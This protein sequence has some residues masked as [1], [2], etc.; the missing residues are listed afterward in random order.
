ISH[1]RQSTGRIN[2]LSA[3]V[4]INYRSRLDEE[5]NPVNAALPAEEIDKITDLVKQT[6]G[7]NEARGDTLTVTNSQFNLTEET[8]EEI[9][10][11]KAP[12]TIQLAQDIGKQLLI[13]A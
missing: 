3:A 10:F 2:R 13:A 8:F 9:P 7:F 11:W 12:E 5:G 6:I 1:T 4:V